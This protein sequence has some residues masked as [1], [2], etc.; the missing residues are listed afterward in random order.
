[1]CLWNSSQPSL[2]DHLVGI[3]QLALVEAYLQ[4][5]VVLP[6]DDPDPVAHLLLQ[7]RDAFLVGELAGLHAERLGQLIYCYLL[8]FPSALLQPDYSAAWHTARLREH[9]HS[10]GA[11]APYPLQVAQ[12]P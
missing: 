12:L 11:F 2:Q 6:L 1:M 9:F 3:A 8:R 10:E 4:R 5:V 7:D